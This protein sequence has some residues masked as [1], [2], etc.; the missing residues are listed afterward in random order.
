VY[1]EVFETILFYA[2]LS[3]AGRGWWLLA[4]VAAGAL[5]L[6]IIAWLLLRTSRRLPI[7]TFFSASSLL[8]A[9][10]AVVLTG[11]GI[12]ALQEAGWIPVSL[13]PVPHV[14]L[15]GIFPTWQSLAAQLAIVAVLI[16]GFA[17]IHRRERHPPGAG[18]LPRPQS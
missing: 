6:G 17:M 7:A 11:K 1:R 5:V 12:A 15:L 10:L 13:A 2:A 8:I 16:V 4:G 3:S 14:E 18:S 9:V